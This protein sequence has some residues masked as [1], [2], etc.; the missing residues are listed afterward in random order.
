MRT[1]V[2]S[3]GLAAVAAS[4]I[5]GILGCSS[6]TGDTPKTPQ[7]GSQPAA[8]AT[9]SP[10]HQ[11]YSDPCTMAAKLQAAGFNVT[12]ED[13]NGCDPTHTYTRDFGYQDN[14]AYHQPG[15][16]WVVLM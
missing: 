15:N 3:A 11:R 7:N 14:G 13:G 2:K 5:F 4:L 12:D 9:E 1:T 8:V 16:E 6:S 10:V